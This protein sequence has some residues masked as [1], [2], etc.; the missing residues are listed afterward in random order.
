MHTVARFVKIPHTVYL[1]LTYEFMFSFLTTLSTTQTVPS[2]DS[3]NSL[4]NNVM[5]VKR[6]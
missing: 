2:L 5:Q 3:L 6:P 4:I 1:L